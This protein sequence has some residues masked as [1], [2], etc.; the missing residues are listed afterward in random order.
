MDRIDNNSRLLALLPFGSGTPLQVIPSIHVSIDIETGEFIGSIHSDNEK[1]NAIV[2]EPESI[3]DNGIDM[4]SGEYYYKSLDRTFETI[5]DWWNKVKLL[6]K[7]FHGISI[8]DRIMTDPHTVIDKL[9]GY[10]KLRLNTIKHN[11]GNIK[12]QQYMEDLQTLQ[13]ILSSK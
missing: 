8:P 11:C 4:L 5:P 13:S 1:Q 12:Y 9:P 3:I 7:F 10:I 2:A 6:E